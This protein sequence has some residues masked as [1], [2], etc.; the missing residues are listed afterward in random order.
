MVVPTDWTAKH[1]ACPSNT[2][3]VYAIFLEGSWFFGVFPM[4]FPGL[5]LCDLSVV[6]RQGGGMWQLSSEE[7]NLP[8]SPSQLPRGAHVLTKQSTY[9]D[10]GFVLCPEESILHCPLYHTLDL[11]FY[12]SCNL[13]W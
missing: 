3:C 12:H 1:R 9:I 4:K 7:D 13:C 11:F 2:P 8:P 5:V 10:M 6:L